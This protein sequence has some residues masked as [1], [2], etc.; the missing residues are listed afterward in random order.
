MPGSE[1]QILNSIVLIISTTNA[2]NKD[3][4]FDL[5]VEPGTWNQEL[6]CFLNLLMEF[7]STIFFKQNLEEQEVSHEFI[8]ITF[9]LCLAKESVA[10]LSN[11]PEYFVNLVLPKSD[12]SDLIFLI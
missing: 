3:I 1:C 8:L 10:F 12:S 4:I 5:A 9:F 7:F 11:T 2:F 6:S